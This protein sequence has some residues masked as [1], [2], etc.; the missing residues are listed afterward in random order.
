MSIFFTLIRTTDSSPYDE[1]FFLHFN[2]VVGGKLHFGS[3][4]LVIALCYFS[5]DLFPSLITSPSQLTLGEYCTYFR[6]YKDVPE[7][8]RPITIFNGDAFSPSLE[9]AVMKG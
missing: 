9:S 2:D 6:N 4:L 1:L 3:Y 7:A 5:E 8:E